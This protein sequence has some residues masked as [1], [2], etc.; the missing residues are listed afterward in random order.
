MDGSPAVMVVI[1][2]RAYTSL[3][4]ADYDTISRVVVLPDYQ[5]IGIGSRTMEW[6]G[7]YWWKTY[8]RGLY[9]IAAHP[10]VIYGLS[11]SHAWTTIVKPNRI[12]PWSGSNPG[13]R[14]A[15][16]PS[17]RATFRYLPE[18]FR[19]EDEPGS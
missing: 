4:Y 2:R 8:R 15:Y 18:Q 3:R 6:V 5:G 16:R 12:P 14:A 13:R 1:R 17:V 7:E 11:R 19:S 10:A 9:I